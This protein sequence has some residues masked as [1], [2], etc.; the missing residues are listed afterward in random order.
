MLPLQPQV[1]A[2][3]AGGDG[4]FVRIAQYRFQDELGESESNPCSSAA[5]DQ[6][7]LA[8]LHGFLR[9]QCPQNANSAHARGWLSGRA[10]LPSR[11]LATG[12]ARSS[13]VRS[14]SAAASAPLPARIVTFEA[15]FNRTA[16]LPSS[17][18]V[19]RR[20]LSNQQLG[21]WAGRL[22]LDRFASLSS[23]PWTSFAIDRWATPLLDKGRTTGEPRR[24]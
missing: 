17:A 19:G 11:A 16:A 6:Q 15:P 2:A 18:S 10:A 3:S 5:H 23:W 12:A 21:S 14:S 8:L 13:A 24:T 20:R 22:R 7:R 1:Q 4:Q 9:G